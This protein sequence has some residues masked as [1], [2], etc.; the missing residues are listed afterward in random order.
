[1]I[2]NFEP[3]SPLEAK[4]TPHFEESL[5]D[6]PEVEIFAIHE[7]INKQAED[8]DGLWRQSP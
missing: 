1:M 8:K 7:E 5:F 2:E 6:V 3:K 4:N